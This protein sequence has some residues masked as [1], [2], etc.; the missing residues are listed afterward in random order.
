MTIKISFLKKNLQ[1]HYPRGARRAARSIV[2]WIANHPSN[3]HHLICLGEK[4]CNSRPL[5]FFSD[6]LKPW[7]D[8]NSLYLPM[9]S[10][11]KNFIS[12]IT[13]GP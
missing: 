10:L 12:Q 13:A 1:D 2:E 7:L 6:E 11:E 5:S 3:N 9:N 8:S 4:I